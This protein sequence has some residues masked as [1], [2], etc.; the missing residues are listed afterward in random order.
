MACRRA[1]IGAVQIQSDT[2]AELVYHLL[3]EASVS[4]HRT[5]LSAVKALLYAS[6]ERVVGGATYV[7][8]CADDL[9]RVHGVLRM[10]KNEVWRST[11]KSTFPLVGRM[12]PI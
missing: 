2:L 8:M 4:A 9:F 3:A 7:W 10:T 5:D 6:N 11:S 12:L 1:D